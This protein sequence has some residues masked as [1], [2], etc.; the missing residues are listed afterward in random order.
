MLEPGNVDEAT[1]ALSNYPIVQAVFAIVTS[2]LGILIGVVALRRGGDKDSS[3]PKPLP[4]PSVDLPSYLMTGHV[5]EMI[6][7][8][9]QAL[10]EAKETREAMEQIRETVHAIL[11]NQETIIKLT[12]ERRPRDRTK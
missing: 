2:F 8:L 3:Q 11:K 12:E 7:L 5:H 10:D 4:M 1:K 9:R 6:G